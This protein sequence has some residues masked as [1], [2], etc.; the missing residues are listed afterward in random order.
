MYLIGCGAGEMISDIDGSFWSRYFLRVANERTCFALWACPFKPSGLISC[1][2]CTFCFLIFLWETW[3]NHGESARLRSERSG[4]EPW[5]ATL[6]LVLG[7][8]TLLLQRLF[9]PGCVNGY[10]W[11]VGKNLTN[12]GRVTCDGLA[13]RPGEVEILLAASCYRNWDKLQQLRAS[14]P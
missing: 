10:R 1:L 13:S 8:D 12:C 4:F 14:W 5:P 2:K 9:P 3:W 11:I 6:C 7:Q